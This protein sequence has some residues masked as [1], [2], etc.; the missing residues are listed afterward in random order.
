M[1]TVYQTKAR[2]ISFGSHHRYE[3]NSENL[4]LGLLKLEE[5]SKHMSLAKFG[6]FSKDVWLP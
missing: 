6:D 2:T 3:M 4:A 5:S 1:T